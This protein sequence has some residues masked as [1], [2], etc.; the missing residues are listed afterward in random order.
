M[1]VDEAVRDRYSAAAQAA[2]PALCCPVTYDPAYLEILPEEILERDYGCGN[3]AKWIQEGE[4]V[5][6]LGSGGGKICYIAAQI[7]GRD[8]RV[9]GVDI[10]DDMLALARKY[11]PDIANTL[12]Y[13]NVEFRKGRI[14]DLALDLDALDRILADHPIASSSDW[15][16]VDEESHHLRETAPLI[17]D[18]S[19][20]VILSNCVLNLVRES[21]RRQL[22]GEMYR[23]LK[24]GGR[25]VI[26]DIV[27]DED[28][29]AELRND[30]KLWSGCLSGA[31]REDAFL[32]AFE[33]AG[34]YGIE[35][36]D[37]QNEPWAV[38]EGI[39]F[40]SLTVRGFRG[41]DGP[42]LDRKQ[43]VI[44]NGPWKAVIDD[45]GHKLVRGRR[46]AVCE[47]T[48]NLY[49]KAPYGDQITPIEPQMAVAAENATPFDCH[50]SPV[51]SPRET[52]N[53]GVGL[54]HV[55]MRIAEFTAYHLRIPLR[56]T[57]RHASHTR[58]TNDTI[59]VCC[60]LDNGIEGWGEGLPRPYV[61]GETIESALEM[62]RTIDYQT[63]FA[64]PLND[65]LTS[66]MQVCEAFVPPI[67]SGDYRDC[68]GNSV[69]CAIELSLLDAA[70][71]DEGVP[72]STVT[73]RFDPAAPIRESREQVHYSGVITGSGPLKEMVR[74]W[75][76]RYYGFTQIK[77]K[78]GVAE[79]NDAATLRR[80]RRII[81]S[82]FDLRLDANE[83]WTCDNLERRLAPLTPFHVTSVEQ[84]VPHEQVDGLAEIRKRIETPLMLDESLC[85]LGDGQRAI[86][87]GTCDLFNIRISKCGGFLNSLK[88]AA[89]A[90][91]AGLGYQLGCQVGETGILSAA[92]RHFATSV[93]GIRYLEGS[94][95]RFLVR[96]PL[97]QEDLTF[98][99]RGLA[100]AITGAGLGIT[101]D[102]D[103]VE[104]TLMHILGKILAWV[105]VI[106]AGASTTLMSRQL[107]IRNSYTKKLKKLKE[108]NE[109]AAA[110]IAKK[111]K[112]LDNLNREYESVMYGWERY[113]DKRFGG[114]YRT[115]DP[116]KSALN[117][118]KSF[119]VGVGTNE[120]IGNDIRNPAFPVQGAQT[121]QTRLR[122]ILHVFRDNGDGSSTYVGP[123][124][125]P[126][127][128]KTDAN[129]TPQQTADRLNRQ[130]GLAD[131]QPDGVRMVPMWALRPGE[132]DSWAGGARDGWRY[133]ATVEGGYP[134][135][136]QSYYRAIADLEEKIVIARKNLVKRNDE[137][138]A[139]QDEV[140]RY[141]EIV[142]GTDGTG[143]ILA[144]LDREDE[145]RNAIQASVDLLRRE[146]KKNVDLRTALV[147][148]IRE[149]AATLPGSSALKNE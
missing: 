62:L 109:A 21:D 2:E 74:A 85:S 93:G 13:D 16:R 68:F 86:E 119:Q 104:R 95:D 66:A 39:E 127:I 146:V 56:K 79:A 91:E 80:V 70:A 17:A 52:K 51:R 22:F 130:A 133:W 124:Q 64:G 82:K 71:R 149:L 117:D 57:I 75:K 116:A 41:K 69:K 42:C 111:E 97:C 84:P 29:P 108:E 88:L 76:Y 28:V 134:E 25:A 131:I 40:Y 9:I 3:P 138:K 129:E 139:A 38:I 43:A 11:Q 34:F 145:K 36:V 120:G 67:P 99:R 33:D 37:R 147:A 110:R 15:L 58:R 125:F 48:F 114:Q 94:F 14:Q 101:I 73:A 72:L 122:Q 24:R 65:G 92:G 83:A 81:G 55:I 45:D 107:Q 10:N 126:V 89:M 60:R 137:L 53:R 148:K 23:V 123:F 54:T 121:F 77:V 49:T 98:G 63:A 115:N 113:W 6:D 19:I 140:N 47:K 44:Y 90:R 4:T 132:Y 144:D 78:V 136:V 141:R 106:G 61:T 46:S 1:N 59:V 7:V 102:R 118:G 8:G 30:P 31:F 27:S 87:R 26:S 20:D 96:E 135:Q 18:G 12:G 103:A 32:Q 128:P 35:I 5:L 143:G 105:L 142:A 112:I 50:G 100:P